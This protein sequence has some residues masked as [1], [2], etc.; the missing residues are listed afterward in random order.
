MTGCMCRQVVGLYL[1]VVGRD[2]WDRRGSHGRRDA[3]KLRK[4][5]VWYV[6]VCG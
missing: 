3:E 4:D 6:C 5:G 2:R 1:L